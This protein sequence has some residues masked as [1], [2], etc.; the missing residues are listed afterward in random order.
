MTETTCRCGQPTRDAA[1]VCETCADRLAVALGEVPWLAEELEVSIT[2]QRAIPNEGKGSSS[3]TC[4]CDDDDDDC[5]HGVLPWRDEASEARRTLHGLLAMWARFCEEE[6]VRHSSPRTR[7]L[8]EHDDNLPA[9][10]R[11]LLWRVDGLTWHEIGPEAV[12]EITDAVAECHRMIDRRPDRWY[13]GPCTAET[14]DGHCG[15]DLY[16]RRATGEVKCRECGAVY[17]VESRRR[18]LLDEAEDRLADAATVARAV[19]WLGAEPLNPERV[20]KWAERGRIA[21]KG[22]DGKRPLYRIGDAIDLLAGDTTR[23]S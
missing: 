13:A 1:Y 11:W 3:A 2:R 10:S 8:D 16:A 9:L 20:R 5:P 17:D 23:A 21:I 15:A 4:S 19:S 18:W 14:E 7:D 12:D 22:H 6:H